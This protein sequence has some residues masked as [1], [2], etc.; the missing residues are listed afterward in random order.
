VATLNQRAAILICDRGEDQDAPRHR[1]KAKKHR[2]KPKPRK[3]GSKAAKAKRPFRSTGGR[4]ALWRRNVTTT[5]RPRIA[6]F[7]VADPRHQGAWP[8]SVSSGIP[9]RRLGAFPPPCAGNARR[10][11]LVQSGERGSAKVSITG[12][13]WSS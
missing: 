2:F 11:A 5:A 12:R 9:C 10:G 6:P 8:R 3:R 4:S 13:G 1:K 7:T